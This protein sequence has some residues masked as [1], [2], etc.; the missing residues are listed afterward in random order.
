MAARGCKTGKAGVQEKCSLA[1][2][3]RIGASGLDEILGGG[4][5]RG[6]LYLLE[7]EP[8]AGKTTVALQFL[9]AGAEAGER[10]LYV[11]LS[12]TELELRDG[13][14]SHGW[15]LDESIVVRELV[16]PE[17]L[18]D[19]DQQ[20][21]LVYASEIELGETM[22]KLFAMIEE[23][24]P[25]RVVLDSLSELR[26]L[27]QG[28][29]RYRRQ[30]LA[31]KHYFARRNATVLMLDDLTSEALDKTVHSIAHAV[32]RL[33]QLAPEYGAERRRLRVLKYRGRAF[34]GGFHDFVI[35][36][37]G[38]VV[39]P[40]LVAVE[41]RSAIERHVRSSGLDAFDSL[42]GG[43]IEAGTS[44][45]LLGPSGA[46]KSL[47]AVQFIAAAVARGE[48]VALYVFDEE[49]GLLFQRTLAIGIDLRAMQRRGDLL[50]EQVDAAELSPGEFAHRVTSAVDR[51]GIGMVV[52]DSITG[53]QLAMP[54]EHSLVLHL[55]ELLLSLN[56]RGATTIATLAQAGL[57]GDMKSSIDITYI[58]DTVVLLRYFEAAGEVRRAI[59]VIKKRAGHHESAIRELRFGGEGLTIGSMLRDF[60]G[61]LRGAPRFV[62]R[63]DALLVSSQ[64]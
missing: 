34:R 20:Q 32:V 1:G 57:V 35:R 55:H 54:E 59:S 44:T 56:R 64:R 43:G 60:Q 28:S 51:E 38:V 49:I 33:E 2:D 40:R 61:V 14:A 11:S 46:G 45:L 6:R 26:L 13:A 41:R 17:S 22:Q 19:H 5:G 52:V 58:A 25:D 12:E 29:L 50:I 16:P 47:I 53:Y 7:G 27:A 23:L 63:D 62:G 31:L 36:R 30:I 8:G 4:L 48:K 37:E 10:S 15:E 18:L 3:A 21:S 9:I 24:Q 39:F 42:L